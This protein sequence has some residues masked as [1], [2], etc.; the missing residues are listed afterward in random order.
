MQPTVG[1]LRCAWA[2]VGRGGLECA[3]LVKEA[4][5]V[6]VSAGGG[7]MEGSAAVLVLAVHVEAP[8]LQHAPQLHNVGAL[9]GAVHA[10]D[11]L[12]ERLRIEEAGTVGVTMG[13]CLLLRS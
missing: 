1:N 5:G 4:A 7:D 3:R 6:K 10:Q 2:C 8:P 11:I 9:C 12:G 13:L